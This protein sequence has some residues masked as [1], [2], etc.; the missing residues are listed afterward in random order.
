[1]A[2][3]EFKSVLNSIENYDT[4]VIKR[5]VD[6]KD[7]YRKFLPGDRLILLGCGHVAQAVCKIASLLDFEVTAV[8]ERPAF[9]NTHL[10]PDAKKVICNSFAPALEELKIK[11]TDYVCCMTRG[12]RYDAVCIRHIMSHTMPYYLGMVGSR[13]RV[14]DF[15]EVL[16]DE[17]FSEDRIEAMH[18]P[19]GLSIHAQTPAEIGISIVAELV[20]E[21]RK[22]APEGN[23]EYLEQK[24]T[25]MD[26]LRFLAEDD[27]P[28][29]FM[30]VLYSDGSVPA[31]PGAVMAVDKIKRSFGT[32]GGGCSEAELLTKAHRLIGT[33]KSDVVEIDMTNDVAAEI[34]MVCGGKM[35]TYI[36][37]VKQD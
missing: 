25:D 2:N 10:F 1:M 5:S 27:T 3:S 16:R 29:A 36:E 23:I 28:K 18:A 24:N 37:D 14:A 12:H 21:R 8:D 32:V 22:A 34:G 9:A 20:K 17:G 35:W 4:H 13:K 11:P 15:K 31:K 7:Y 19:I 26:V 33:G 6:G 30:M